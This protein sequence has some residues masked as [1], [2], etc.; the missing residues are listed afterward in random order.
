MAIISDRLSSRTGKPSLPQDISFRLVRVTSVILDDTHPA[1]KYLG[2]W[3][4]L[5][6]IFYVDPT[7]AYSQ[8]VANKDFENQN[9]AR[10]YFSNQK[11]YPLL[12]ELVFMVEG[13]FSKNL[14]NTTLRDE[15]G[16]S[17][18][19]PPVNIWNHPHNNALP[20]SYRSDSIEQGPSIQGYE[21]TEN[22]IILRKKTK[23]DEITIPLGNNFIE[24]P[25]IKPLLPYEGDNIIEGRFGNSIRFGATTAYNTENPNNK[26]NAWS[27][28]SI[29]GKSTVDNKEGIVGDPIIII[30]NGQPSKAEE[31]WIPLLEDINK[32]N[33]SIYMTSNQSISNLVVATAAKGSPDKTEQNS[34]YQDLDENGNSVK[35]EFAIEGDINSNP[36]VFVSEGDASSPLIGPVQ[37]PEYI[38]VPL[39]SGQTRDLINVSESVYVEEG[40]SFYDE[41]KKTGMTDDDFEDYEDSF[42]NTLISGELDGTNDDPTEGTSD[43]GGGST[44]TLD[45]NAAEGWKMLKYVES[46]GEKE[47]KKGGKRAVFEFL[48][49]PPYERYTLSRLDKIRSKSWY[50]SAVGLFWG[51]DEAEAVKKEIADKL[52][53]HK[54]PGKKGSITRI[55]NPLPWSDFK[56]NKETYISH[57]G[58]RQSTS[59]TGTLRTGFGP[60]ANS[61]KLLVIHVTAG[62]RGRSQHDVTYGHIV[63]TGSPT[64]NDRVGYHL[65]ILENG[66]I[67]KLYDDEDISYGVIGVAGGTRSKNGKTYKIPNVDGVNE[68]DRYNDVGIGINIIGS[69]KWKENQVPSKAQQY[70][71]NKIV[72][73]YM[74]VRYPNGT[75]KICGHNQVIPIGQGKS[76]PGFDVREYAKALGL[77][78]N[79]IVQD[80]P[81][82]F[83]NIKDQAKSYK[84]E[85]L[86][87]YKQRGIAIA[88]EVGA[89][90]LSKL[91]RKDSSTST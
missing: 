6:T 62:N 45:G 48:G 19:F 42:S 76:C 24:K 8:L 80:E 86:E 73:H 60:K 65:Y 34:Y 38:A 56:N 66:D 40:L 39:E 57:P 30:R 88:N 3:D 9:H 77:Q 7:K 55:M 12:G 10:P 50:Q 31:G 11:T 64:K 59:A 71:L 84:A 75:I 41:L 36:Y 74:N 91:T 15:N 51:D 82:C 78:P 37:E 21:A 25:N 87:V 89:L 1:W 18:Y 49:V 27:V 90:E 14:M 54:Y 2:G 17:Y 83:N 13:L 79:Q 85:N 28:N 4:S 61:K 16:I 72:K 5:G 29:Q 52:N 44:E 67:C 23:E 43:G 20:Q 32:D 26:Q 69:H 46:E 70:T 35:D 47:K 33:S 63:R 68:F 58:R 53:H 81:K 22:G